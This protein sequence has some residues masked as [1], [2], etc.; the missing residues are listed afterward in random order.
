MIVIAP[1][2]V[3]NPAALETRQVPKK[4]FRRI[5]IL[6][7]RAGI[8]TW[9]RIVFDVQ[10]L[11]YLV[12]LAPFVI[13][14][15]IWPRLAFPIAQAPILMVLLVGLIEMKMLRVSKTARAGM[16]DEDAAAR[17][18]DTLRF[19]AR[20]ILTRLAAGKALSRH[21]L[22]LVVEQSEL[23][24]VPPLTLVS[25]QL[26]GPD[27]QLLP[28][29]AGEQR[30][31]REALFDDDLTERDLLRINLR[32]DIFL[33]DVALEARGVSAH[34]RLAALIE[35]RAPQAQPAQ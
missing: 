29:D 34:A 3:F 30:L 23:A 26:D 16:I 11:R 8:G 27:P 28:L 9:A 7:R 18:L 22:H 1:N 10:I 2:T 20:T 32:E 31:I 35:Q 15:L 21:R 4:M 13:A 25:V 24:R 33:R 14:M 19:R 12:A 17:G 6:P 5:G